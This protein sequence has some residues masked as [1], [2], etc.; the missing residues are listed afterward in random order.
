MSK[1]SN[2]EAEKEPAVLDIYFLTVIWLSHIQIWVSL[3]G[4]ASLTQW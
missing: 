4:T 2:K 1:G 3:K